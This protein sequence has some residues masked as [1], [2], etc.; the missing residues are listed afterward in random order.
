[1]EIT[2]L[3][4][5]VLEVRKWKLSDMDTLLKAVGRGFLPALLR[6][7]TDATI[8]VIDPGIYP[9]EW[10]W[11]R[12]YEG[13]LYD[14]LWT[15]RAL[16]LGGSYPFSVTCAMCKRKVEVPFDVST[17]TR[18]PVPEELFEQLKI[19]KNRIPVSFSLG[20]AVVIVPTADEAQALANTAE[21]RMSTVRQKG[22]EVPA[23]PETS[24]IRSLRQKLLSVT[25]G[26]TTYEGGKL[27]AWLGDIDL[28]IGGE[29]IDIIEE[30]SFG[31]DTAAEFTCGFCGNTFPGEVPMQKSFF[32]LKGGRR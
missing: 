17:I 1:M 14:A 12:V 4:G 24:L 5:A 16:S 13:D 21:K 2:L 18:K 8:R 15:W 20:S 23:E 31:V 19:G 7:F 29:L 9:A 11:G 25:V 27:E 28:D 10:S 26:E 22:A 32:L 3:T 6:V 30:K